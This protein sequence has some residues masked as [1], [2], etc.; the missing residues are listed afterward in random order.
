ML[1]TDIS[2][3]NFILYANASFT[4][5]SPNI[6]KPDNLF[7]Q[8]PHKRQINTIFKIKFYRCHIIFGTIIQ[9]NTA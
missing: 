4:P 8:F 7:S 5:C 1:L 6:A 3:D 2:S 9:K